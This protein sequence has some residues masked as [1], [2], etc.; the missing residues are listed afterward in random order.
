MLLKFH[1]FGEL[2]KALEADILLYLKSIFLIVLRNREIKLLEINTEVC[3]LEIERKRIFIV[4]IL[5]HRLFLLFLPLIGTDLNFTS[6]ILCMRFFLVTLHLLFFPL[7][8]LNKLTKPDSFESDL[9]G[10]SFL[11]FESLSKF[12]DDI[13]YHE[14]IFI[15]TLLKGQDHTAVGV[16]GGC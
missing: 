4:C 3:S 5:F 14:G 1:K 9:I 8:N 7:L 16:F 12:R 13:H 10:C 6:F 2:I 15:I 11:G